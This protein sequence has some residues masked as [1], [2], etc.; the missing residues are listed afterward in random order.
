MRRI[1]KEELCDSCRE[2]HPIMSNGKENE[3]S[4]EDMLNSSGYKGPTYFF[5]NSAILLYLREN[6]GCSE[7]IDLFE[8]VAGE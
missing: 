1:Q 7:C 4:I 2:I 3:H 8:S 5:L 6:G